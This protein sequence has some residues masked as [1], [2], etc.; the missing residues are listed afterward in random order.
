MFGSSPEVANGQVKFLSALPDI[1]LPSDIDVAA[2]IP[3]AKDPDDFTS[4]MVS[5]DL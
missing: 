2:K 1:P 4:I 3:A 5:L